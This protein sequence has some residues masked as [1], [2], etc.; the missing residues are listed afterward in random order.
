[1]GDH[2][3]RPKRVRSIWWAGL[4]GGAIG[5]LSFIVYLVAEFL[6]VAF[7]N[8]PRIQEFHFDGMM[9]VSALSFIYGG[10]MVVPLGGLA[11]VVLH[12]LTRR[13]GAA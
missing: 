11:G 3:I 1:M 7:A 5:T 6:I 12:T 9:F 8:L 4:V 2:L 10:W 13:G